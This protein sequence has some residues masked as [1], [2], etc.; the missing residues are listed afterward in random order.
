MEWIG[1]LRWQQLV[2]Y[3]LCRICSLIITLLGRMLTKCTISWERRRF[4]KYYVVATSN[5][6]IFKGRAEEWSKSE[7]VWHA[8]KSCTGRDDSIITNWRGSCS[9][10]CFSFFVPC[11]LT[12]PKDQHKY[13]TRNWIM[14]NNKF[15]KVNIS[16]LQRK[17]MNTPTSSYRLNTNYK[18]GK[19]LQSQCHFNVRK[20]K[21][22]VYFY[23]FPTWQSF[24]ISIYKYKYYEQR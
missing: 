18:D 24:P 16:N 19:L 11:C 22:N 7:I 15:V 5:V 8:S 23:C 13:I 1:R 17:R 4:V 10:Y 2:N 20:S 14:M 9:G 21:E 3:S 6:Y 12:K